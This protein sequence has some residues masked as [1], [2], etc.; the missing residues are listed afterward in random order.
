MHRARL[1]SVLVSRN[2]NHV[3]SGDHP[4][5]NG[6]CLVDQT[7]GLP[8]TYFTT[9]QSLP[10]SKSINSTGDARDSLCVIGHIYMYMLNTT[11]CF[12]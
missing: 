6:V 10:N 2:F 12:I 1:P 7:L 9:H 11:L 8:M 5:V 4:P 3:N